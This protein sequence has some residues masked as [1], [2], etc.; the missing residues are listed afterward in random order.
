MAGDHTFMD[1]KWRLLMV[2]PVSPMLWA[3]ESMFCLQA[4]IQYSDPMSAANAKQ[5]L[6]GHAI[7]DGGY[8]RVSIPLYGY[9]SQE[10]CEVDV[11]LMT[12]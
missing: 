12:N 1:T 3:S 9:G 11:A 2:Q 7:Y 4:L 10:G 5:A 6:E 8:N